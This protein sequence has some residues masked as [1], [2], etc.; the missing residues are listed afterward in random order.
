MTIKKIYI[1]NVRGIHQLTISDQIYKNRPTILVAPNGFGKTSIASAF[2]S[3]IEKTSMQI[4][5]EDRHRHNPSAKAQI[6]L[7]YE[8]NKIKA[9]FNATE[10]AR[11]NDIRKHFD[12]NVISDLRTIKATTPWTPSGQ[13]KPK[14]KSVIEPITICS[15]VIKAETPFK[16]TM[17]YSELGRHKTA[18]L[19]INDK[20]F[21]CRDFVM[22]ATDF[23]EKASALLKHKKYSK[24]KYIKNQLTS[25][26][27]T[28]GEALSDI[29]GEIQ[30]LLD[31]EED[32]RQLF[33]IIQKT[34]GLQSTDSF[35]AIWQILRLLENSSGPLIDHLQWRRYIEIKK[36][37]DDGLRKLS[38]SSWKAPSSKETKGNLVVELPDPTHISNGQ[39]DILVLLSLLHIARYNST[40]SKSILVIDEIFD[41]LDDAN[42][43]V[44]QYYISQLIEDYDQQGR[45]IYVLLLTHLN[46]SFFRNYVFSNQK[47]IYLDKSAVYES[48]DA[49]KKLLNAR[50]DDKYKESLKEQIAKYLVHYHVDPYDFTSELQ[51]VSGA[52][53]SWGKDGKF[54]DFIDEEYKKYCTD[55]PYDPLAICAITRRKV[56]EKAFLQISSVSDAGNFFTTHGTAPKLDFATQR[57]AVTPESHYLLRVIYDD[58]LHWNDSRDNMIPIVAKL[59]H[60]IIKSM[61]M[62]TVGG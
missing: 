17:F 33:K 54:Q 38:S 57:G 4:S 51:A 25:H 2:K 3:V 13:A 55:K 8:E 24:I 50:K 15:K 61:I 9:V 31:R 60:P 39:R 49:M 5:D 26:A 16:K 52:R 7:T 23:I 36:S 20:V 40:K 19:D 53:S 10:K 45:S 58:G 30:L 29:A 6:E 11:S 44:A 32:Y 34:T 37:L 35:L 41:Y 27:G 48:V 42:M 18:L 21:S 62:E 43:T 56:E 22:R 59:S 28:T 14:G 46:P 1:E 12:I 47:V